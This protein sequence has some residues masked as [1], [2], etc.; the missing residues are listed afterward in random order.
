LNKRRLQAKT[1]AEL[2]R[3]AVPVLRGVKPVYGADAATGKSLFSR[4]V[5]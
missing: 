3:A 5:G 2:H 1:N 4:T